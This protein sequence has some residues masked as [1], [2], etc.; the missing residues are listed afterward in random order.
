MKRIGVYYDTQKKDENGTWWRGETILEFD[1]RDEIIGS[2]AVGM[3]TCRSKYIP[4]IETLIESAEM[5]KGRKY[6][7]GSIKFFELIKSHQD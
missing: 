1:V 5:L 3:N 7:K 2:V 6:I 4:E